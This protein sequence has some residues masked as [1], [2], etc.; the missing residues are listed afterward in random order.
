MREV[1]QRESQTEILADA[2]WLLALIVTFI[3]I[4]FGEFMLVEK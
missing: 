2:T 4:A 3:V 1:E